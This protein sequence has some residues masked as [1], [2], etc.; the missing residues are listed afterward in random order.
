[1]DLVD[2]LRALPGLLL[3]GLAPGLALL[4]LVQ[5]AMPGRWRVAAAPGLSIGLVGLVG[6]VEHAAHV[7]FEPATVL[8]PLL[9]LV[10]AAALVRWRGRGRPTATRAH[11]AAALSG[12]PAR[13][14][15][16]AALV[17]GLLSASLAVVAFRAQ[18]LPPDTDNPIHAYVTQ[19]IATQH[20]VAVSQPVPAVGTSAVRDRVAFEA[21]AS[22]VAAITGMRPEAAMLPLVLL[23]VVLLPMSL[24]MLAFEATRNW[25]V[26]ALA[27]VLGIGFTMITWALEFGEFPYLADATLVVPLVI[28]ARRALLGDERT[29]NL[30]LCGACVAAMWVTHGLEFLTALAV[31]VPFAVASLRGRSLRELVIGAL[32]VGVAVLAGAAL[33]TVLT[34][35]QATPAAVAPDGVAASSQSVQMLARMGS[36]A[37]MFHALADFVRS[38]LVVPAVLL[39]VL[40]VAASLLV[41]GVRWVLVAHVLLLLIL[42]DVGYGGVLMRVWTPVFP[43]SGADRVVSIQWF[44]VP[45]LMAWGAVNAG[46]V[47]RPLLARSR[48]PRMALGLGG[49]VAVLAVVAVVTSAAHTLSDMRSS[50]A[51]S[52]LT[53]PADVAALA[54]MDRALPPG[55]TVLTDTGA[56]GGQWVDVLTRDVEWAPLSF[57][58]NYVRAGSIQPAVDPKVDALAHACDDPSAARAGLSGIGAVFVG[59]RAQ[60]D[61]APLRWDA[62]C[63]AALSGVRELAHAGD[64]SSSAWVFA[65]SPTLQAASPSAP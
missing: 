7:P 17:A 12:R 21:T 48:N 27:P 34:P 55:T 1:M 32:G 63:I 40:G 13:I 16:G 4:S 36:R 29:R 45:L 35:H 24:A 60:S 8:P 52:T 43:W 39:Y 15:A 25:R 3:L 28:A 19:A 37:Q 62:S 65:V 54:A 22:Q 6:L 9:V 31:G 30:L 5:P 14:V 41:R 64:G 26:A 47:F 58:R 61:A 46:V 18:P 11:Q 44:V 51:G 42:A 23:C 59:T 38:E 33:V 20:D 57:T 56:D 49:G 2:L 53:S 50:V 10:V